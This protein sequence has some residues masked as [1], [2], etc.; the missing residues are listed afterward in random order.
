MSISGVTIALS[1]MQA[2]FSVFHTAAVGLLDGRRGVA[3]YTDQR[4]R[5]PG[6]CAARKVKIAVD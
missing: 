1:G 6:A 4:V 5:D 2:K 3:Q